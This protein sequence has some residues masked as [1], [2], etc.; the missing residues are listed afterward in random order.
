MIAASKPLRVV[1]REM[2]AD[3]LHQ[4]AP[5]PDPPVHILQQHVERELPDEPR[6]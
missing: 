6:Q 4:R 2:A 3:W 1:N 5:R